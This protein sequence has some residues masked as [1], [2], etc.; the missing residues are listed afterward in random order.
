MIIMNLV[1]LTMNPTPRQTN[2]WQLKMG[3]LKMH[4]L[5]NIGIFQLAMLVY[6]RKTPFDQ[7]KGAPGCL[8]YIGDAELPI[9]SGIV[10]KPL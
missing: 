6:Q 4:F 7:W 2:A 5:L 9:Y 8:D 1:N 3:Q 10:N